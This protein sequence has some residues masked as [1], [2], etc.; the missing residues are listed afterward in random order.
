M[1]TR[2]TDGN[3]TNTYRIVFTAAAILT[4][5]CVFLFFLR[6]STVNE[7]YR[8]SFSAMLDGT[9]HRPFVMR[10]LI[11]W[12]TTFTSMIFPLEIRNQINEAIAN[13]RIFSVILSLY[14]VSADQGF[15]AVVSLFWQFLSL[16]GYYFSFR[17]LLLKNFDVSEK[18]AGRL[19]LL[20][21]FGLLPL[22]FFGYIY[23][24]PQ[25]FLCTLAFAAIAANRTILYFIVFALAVLNKETAVVLAIPSI[26]LFWNPFMPSLLKAVK[27]AGYQLLIFLAIRI[28]LIVHFRKNPGMVVE[29]HLRTHIEGMIDYPLYGIAVTALFLCL[30]V[31]FL[32]KWKQKPALVNLGLV[33]GAILMVLF[34][35]GGMPQE[36]RVFYEVIGVVLISI[37][38]TFSMRWKL[39]LETKAVNTEEFIRSVKQLFSKKLIQ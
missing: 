4:S 20:S 15:E 32:Y 1:K 19:T 25:L 7:N 8:A 24:L 33:S 28:P 11:P 36:F 22:M 26:L 17:F 14:R 23:D 13:S 18:K 5:L 3:T 9:A 35:L 37:L 12:L 16:P 38:Q 29:P 10:V 21:T 30:T 34:L 39:A 2:K 31:L 6:F 27:G